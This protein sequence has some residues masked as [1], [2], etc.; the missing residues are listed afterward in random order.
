MLLATS[1]HTHG[2]LC[3]RLYLEHKYSHA[4]MM[5]NL[6]VQKK[7]MP[8]TTWSKR[9]AAP[10]LQ[11]P[12]AVLGELH[13]LP[14]QAFSL[15]FVSNLLPALLIPD[16]SAILPLRYTQASKHV[17]DKGL[18]S[19]PWSCRNYKKPEQK[20]KDFLLQTYVIHAI[21]IPH[22]HIIY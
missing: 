6:R 19:L 14:E 10:S 5:K 1:T 7:C 12:R 16:L 13:A 20:G 4:F 18:T 15:L 2:K 3:F 9:F 21:N 11:C 8:A 17:R 22:K